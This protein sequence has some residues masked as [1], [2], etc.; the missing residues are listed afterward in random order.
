MDPRTLNRRL[1]VGVGGGVGKGG[2]AVRRGGGGGRGGML[3]T[4]SITA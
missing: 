1:V 2:P 4:R 3:M